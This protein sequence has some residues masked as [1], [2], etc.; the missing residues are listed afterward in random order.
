[1]R[2]ITSG[3]YEQS[4][5]HCECY[6]FDKNKEMKTLFARCSVSRLFWAVLC[7]T[8]LITWADQCLWELIQWCEKKFY[9]MLFYHMQIK[10]LAILNTCTVHLLETSRHHVT[11]Q[12]H[13]AFMIK[14]N[15]Q[16]LTKETTSTQ[17]QVRH[18][19]QVRHMGNFDTGDNF[20]ITKTSTERQ[21]RHGIN[22]DTVNN[23]DT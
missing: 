6:R 19:G 3:R 7:V 16:L 8:S 12:S 1:M 20:V 18:W 23:F 9:V 10:K 22:F 2:C 4:L 21:F 13:K 11:E 15:V 17:K 14:G 5:E